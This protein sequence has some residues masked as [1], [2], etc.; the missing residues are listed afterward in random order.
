L[1]CNSYIIGVSGALQ[2]KANHWTEKSSA[3]QK[4]SRI[5]YMLNAGKIPKWTE[6]LLKI[7]PDDIVFSITSGGDNALAFLIDDPGR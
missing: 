6:S 2:K 5:F 7:R 3:A 1:G 4:Y